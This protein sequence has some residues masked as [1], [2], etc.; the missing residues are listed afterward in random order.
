MNNKGIF[1]T[2]TDTGV[3]KT[4]VSALIAYYLKK[5]G[6]NVTIMKP[7][8]TGALFSRRGLI[9]QD[10]E[11]VKRVS[12]IT[13]DDRLSCPY[14][15][16]L[17][18]SP[19][20]AF[21]AK[22]KS[23]MLENIFNA[24]N[25]LCKMYEFV[26]V[27]GAGG[28]L[29]PIKEN[30]YMADLARDLNLPILIISRPSLGTINHTLLTVEYAR[31]R[32][33]EVKGVVINYSC[34]VNKDLSIRRN[35]QIISHLGAVA[36]IG[37]V[38]YIKG[39][40]VDRLN[41]GELKRR[42]RTYIDVESII[43]A[44]PTGRRQ[45]TQT[46]RRWDKEFIWH[47]FTQMQDWLQED[48]L[49]ITEGRGNYLKDS[50]GRWYLDGI[51]SLWVNVHGHRKREID[52]AIREQL[53]RIAHST[54]L[55]LSNDTAILLSKRL[56]EIA[57][58]NLS[59]VFYSDNGS[60]AVEIALKMAF[61]YWQQKQAPVKTKRK[62]ISFV[63][64][65]HGDTVG[66][67]SVG[68]IDLFHK[69]YKPLLFGTIKVNAPYCY[70]C[71]FNKTYPQCKLKC[72]DELEGILR[73]E[74]K[75]IAALI[76]EPQVQA[77]AGMITQPKG[78]LKKL[79][80]L[81]DKYNVLLILDEVA[82]GFGRTGKMF[83]CEH[84]KVNPDILCLAKGF[85][86]GYLP[87][88]ATLTTE[89]IYSAFLGDYAEKK[90]FFHGHSYTANPL[91]CSAALA[92]LDIFEKERTL[93]K[94]RGKIKFLTKE[95]KKF[96]DLSAVGDIRQAGLITGIELV[97][98]KRTKEP[99][100]WEEKIGIRVAMQARKYGVILRP[101]GNVIVLFPPLSITES[102]LKRLLDVT[103][104]SIREVT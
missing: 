14:L 28:I 90:T 57:P 17:P 72:T 104:D 56:I 32:G 85:S 67:V 88:A 63:N 100:R 5:R 37:Q 34:N 11:F 23:V 25:T 2:A 68:G 70:R 20:A 53:N 16:R 12:G 79:R 49:V 47:P 22:E 54:F 86:A 13:I 38:P 45:A 78:Y 81:C 55:G 80:Q 76:I 77:A 64:A 59:K 4:V 102:E 93:D 51:S 83:A 35:T 60:T 94:V 84:E 24:F 31:I 33:L 7:A 50:E 101:L 58:P 40:D 36:V 82:V 71:V 42:D 6:I 29:V 73:R 43:K 69:T 30:Y 74:H 96:Y 19:Y 75:N 62:F 15:N 48:P 44:K 8:Q 65:Y 97:K 61:Q 91:A 21:S 87:L 18:L 10:V 26:I 27:E 99:Y 66:S 103:Y 39:I 95:L 98:D 41:T 92:N 3:G 1:I 9:S 46:L 89:E 52:R